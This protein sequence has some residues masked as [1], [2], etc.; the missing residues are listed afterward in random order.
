MFDVGDLPVLTFGNSVI[1]IN[2]RGDRVVFETTHVR[3][4]TFLWGVLFQNPKTV[5]LVA[6]RFNEHRVATWPPKLCRN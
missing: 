3:F 6:T 2:D 1:C 5:F 4:L